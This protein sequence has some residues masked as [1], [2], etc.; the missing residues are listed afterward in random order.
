MAAQ[1]L[2]LLF[3]KDFSHH[4]QPYYTFEQTKTR[5]SKSEAFAREYVKTFKVRDSFRKVGM[6]PPAIEKKNYYVQSFPVTLQSRNF[7]YYIDKEMEKMAE[8]VRQKGITPEQVVDELAAIAFN[9]EGEFVGGPMKV[10]T[11]HK[12]KAL[13]MLAKY[14]GLYEK[15]N[16]QKVANTQLLQIAFVGADVVMEQQQKIKREKEIKAQTIDD[17]PE[18]VK[19]SEDLKTKIL[20]EGKLK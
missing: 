7:R 11:D 3:G 10:T 20:G 19:R 14:L 18:L 17:N 8:I 5:I 16:K 15:D 4:P 12:L 1:V 2:P 13:D 6:L 9:S